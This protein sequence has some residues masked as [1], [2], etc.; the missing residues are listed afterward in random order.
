MPPARVLLLLFFLG[1]STSTVKSKTSFHFTSMSPFNPLL[2]QNI[3]VKGSVFA[4]G[5]LDGG[6]EAQYDDMMYKLEEKALELCAN[7]VMEFSWSA[8]AY[9]TSDRRTHTVF[10][11]SG[12]A[13]C[14]ES[15]FAPDQTDCS[16]V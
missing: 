16:C 1:I 6:Y 11:G 5:T 4:T 14:D 9:H 2:L 3:V 10:H 12:F 7:S 8:A 15:L 13:V